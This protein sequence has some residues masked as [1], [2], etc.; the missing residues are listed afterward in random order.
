MTKMVRV[1]P[2]LRSF[3]AVCGALAVA[4]SASADPIGVSQLPRAYWGKE[5][6]GPAASRTYPGTMWYVLLRVSDDGKSIETW[7]A[8]GPPGAGTK[9]SVKAEGF[10]E[11][12]IQLTAWGGDTYTVPVR[13]PRAILPL[14]IKL[15]G[16]QIQFS[17][18]NRILG[19][20]DCD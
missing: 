5:C 6:F 18:P 9:Q 13:S 1:G 14:S 15:N 3:L 12:A 19:T 8:Y 16:N 11:Q 10:E 7:S 17:T 20:A 4:T 2:V